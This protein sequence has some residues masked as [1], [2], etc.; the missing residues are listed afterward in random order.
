MDKL[1]KIDEKILY[2]LG[3]NARASYKQIAKNIK[4]KKEV[5]AYHIHQLLKN[6]IITKFVTVFALSKLGIFSSKIYLR[7][8]GLDKEAEKKMYNYLILNPDIAWVAKSVGRWDL[9]IGI[10]TKNIIDFSIKK[11]RILSKFSEYIK[12]YD[13]TQ[14]EDGLVFNRDYLIN[15][16]TTYRKEFVF[17]GGVESINL[18]Q[19]D[20]K[21]IH[22][23]KNN[24]RFQAVDIANQLNLDVRT[25][26]NRIKNLQKRGIIQGFTV[27]INLKQ[28]GIGFHKLCIYLQNHEQKNINSLI[29]FLRE[30]PN[31]VHLIKS[32]G[33]WEIEIETENNNSN[34]IYDFISKLK[35]QFPT[36]IKQIELVTITDELK[37]D[38]F[39]EKS[40]F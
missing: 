36:L 13:V 37:L 18:T 20:L 27:F 29:S 30:Y 21:I 32:L 33:S 22:L 10:Y 23:T 25:V 4:S 17:G 31:T 19:E 1:N 38:F 40:T 15:K 26:T 11:N 5:V 34:N 24:A 35:N 9:L 28:L 8:Q 2:E 39:P 16:P 6:K 14:I 12:D 7:L 3:K